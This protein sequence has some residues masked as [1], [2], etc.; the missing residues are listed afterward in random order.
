[1]I[2]VLVGSALFAAFAIGL[3]LIGLFAGGTDS[4]DAYLVVA[5]LLF[6]IGMSG[7]ILIAV[8]HEER[9]L[10]KFLGQNY[11]DYRKRVPMFVPRLG[12]GHEAVKAR[13]PQP[14]TQR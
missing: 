10:V 2:R 4:L 7:Y 8:R 13:A 14:L 1:M 6:A 9:D 3:G 12:K 11:I 5:M